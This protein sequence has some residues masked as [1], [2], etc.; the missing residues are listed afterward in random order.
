M[1]KLIFIHPNQKLSALYQKKL[2]PYFS[3]DSAHDGLS[4]VRL[5]TKNRP[6]IIVSEFH[7]PDISGTSVLQFVR[8]HQHLN[9]VPFIFL[10]ELNP[11]LES[12]NLGANEWLILAEANPDKLLETC[13]KH[14]KVN[15]P[16]SFAGLSGQEFS[17]V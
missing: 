17:Y 9:S 4:G 11:N 7:L 13:F 6:H 14:L 10:S 8:N 16:Y 15:R 3:V 1:Y 5:I 2:T 12:L